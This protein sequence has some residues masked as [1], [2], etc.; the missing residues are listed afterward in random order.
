VN[1]LIAKT[2]AITFSALIV[3]SLLIFAG[4]ALFAPAVMSEFC[5]NIGDE[6]A[7]LGYAERAYEKDET[8]SNLLIVVKRALAVEDDF[9]VAKYCAILYSETPQGL[10]SDEDSFYKNRYCSA[11]Y[12][13]GER[14]EAVNKASLFSKRYEQ[15]NPLENLIANAFSKKD[16]SFLQMLKAELEYMSGSPE[17]NSEANDRLNEHLEMIN[18]FLNNNSAE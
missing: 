5:V 13:I 16:E 7:A 8:Q 10:S 12:E 9:A 2:A 1:K 14:E 18:K 17:L 3:V 4:L 6:K 11:L 15:G